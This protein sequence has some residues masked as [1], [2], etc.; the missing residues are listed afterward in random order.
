MGFR[1]ACLILLA[2]NLVY[3]PLIRAQQKPFTQDQVHGIVRSGLGEETG[4]KAIEQRGIDFAPTEDFLQSLK[5]APT[6]R[7]G[8][9][10]TAEPNPSFRPA[11]GPSAEPPSHHAG[12]GT[13]HRLRAQ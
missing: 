2:A 8:P 7:R 11:R 4:A 10:K 5:A 9:E 6:G 13:R 12:P 3:A 1:K